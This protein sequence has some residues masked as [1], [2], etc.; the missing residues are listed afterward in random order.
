MD[1]YDIVDEIV[2]TACETIAKNHFLRYGQALFNTL[3]ERY[4]ELANK[5]TGT[6]IDPFYKDTN[7]DKFLSFLYDNVESYYVNEDKS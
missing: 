3:Y 7:I 1:K 5:I 4:P 6:D 2:V